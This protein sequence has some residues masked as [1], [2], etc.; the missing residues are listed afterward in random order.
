MEGQEEL[1]AYCSK[2]DFTSLQ[3][4]TRKELEGLNNGSA[5]SDWRPLQG[6]WVENEPGRKY[7]PY[8]TKPGLLPY[9]LAVDIGGR[10][11]SSKSLGVCIGLSQVS[12][13]NH[14]SRESPTPFDGRALPTALDFELAGQWLRDCSTTHDSCKS[15]VLA[16][17]PLNLFRLIDVQDKKVI[18]I[19]RSKLQCFRYAALSYVWGGPQKFCLEKGNLVA[20]QKSGALRDTPKTIHDAMT[21][22]SGLGLAYIWVDADDKKEQLGQMGKIYA[23]AA[24]CIVAASGDSVYSGIP[25][26][27]SPRRAQVQV[28]LS[29]YN[30]SLLSTL[31][32]FPTKGHT[33][34]DG[35]IWSKRGWTFQERILSRRS[36]VFTDSQ[37]LWSC[38]E[39][40]KTEEAPP[41]TPLAKMTFDMLIDYSIPLISGHVAIKNYGPA[42]YWTWLAYDFVQRGFSFSGDTHNALLGAL[43]Y[44]QEKHDFSFLWALPRKGFVLNLLWYGEGHRE[45]RSC[46]TTLPTTSLETRVPFPSWTWL[47]WELGSVGFRLTKL[48]ATVLFHVRIYVLKNSPPRLEL[49]D[50]SSQPEPDA[51]KGLELDSLAIE[52]DG[53]AMSRTAHV[54][55]D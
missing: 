9:A 14:G 39:T 49:V 19:R 21:V 13:Q 6:E 26:L 2:I 16:D 1:C 51:G 29:G 48:R 46:L 23:N 15:S 3:L 20:L 38:G 50:E 10:R 34:I 17:P 31:R 8:L 44:F 28:P 41:D 5:A 55:D 12:D 24:L 22:A 42:S 47:G 36:L 4:P 25:G 11:S 45:R 43:E 30:M 32:S 37:I 52:D 53:L 33:Y 7:S 35:F 27:S 40:Q 54:P 18:E